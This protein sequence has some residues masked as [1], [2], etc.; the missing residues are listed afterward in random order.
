[1]SGI[2]QCGMLIQ[3]TVFRR[4]HAGG[5]TEE[6]I[7]HCLN[8]SQ[9]PNYEGPGRT[10][11]AVDLKPSMA[12]ALSRFPWQSSSV[13]YVSVCPGVLYFYQDAELLKRG[14]CFDCHSHCTY[15]ALVLRKRTPLFGGHCIASVTLL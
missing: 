13:S 5:E 2:V 11:P 10:L 7:I 14:S 12:Q 4:L 1:M 6:R 9:L 3:S 8:V 15:D